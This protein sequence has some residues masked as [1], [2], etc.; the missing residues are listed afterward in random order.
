MSEITTTYP[1]VYIQE[2]NSQ[3]L[4][5][6]SGP[7]A[8][9]LFACTVAD[10]PHL[11]TDTTA[12]FRVDNWV[13]FTQLYY[14]EQSGTGLGGF[15]FNPANPIHVSIKAYFDNGGGYCYI[16]AIADSTVA[17][18]VIFNVKKLDDI[19]LLV[20]A[21]APATEMAYA[22]DILCPAT[23]AEHTMFAILDGNK[24]PSV[25]AE[26][27]PTV[28]AG[29]LPH[30]Y[31]ACY[32]PWLRASWLDVVLV[33]PS[34]VI[35][36]IYCSVDRQ[37]GVWKAPANVA[38]KGG[39]T[40]L[41]KI[42]DDDQAEHM[43]TDDNAAV[44]MIREFVDRGTL[45]W[46]ARTLAAA[47]DLWR[48]VPVRRLFN[49]AEKDIQFSLMASVFEPNSQP[50]WVLVQSAIV[51]YLDAI[52]RQ[53]G[54]LGNTAEEAYFVQVGKGITMTDDDIA[55]GKMIVKIGMSAVRPAEFI[56]LEFTQDVM[57]A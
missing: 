4:S 39:L 13:E 29:N 24:D 28:Y 47:D 44:N 54:L 53:G 57:P 8:V 51:N 2:V 19:T 31:A 46:G 11:A 56:I 38:L 55:Q 49:T 18:D 3:S 43:G 6:A 52:W 36:G 27:L 41:V 21:G 12:V 50:T 23:S 10:L 34:A 15:I 37:V 9:P 30:Q 33:P 42:S 25:S 7:S 17:D 22:M 5:I 48:Y 26:W 40:P 32:F 16:G 1:G 14:L 45:V 35:A 20:N